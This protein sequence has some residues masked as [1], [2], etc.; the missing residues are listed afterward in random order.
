M[1]LTPL[2]QNLVDRVKDASRRFTPP[3]PLKSGH[4]R[5]PH[6]VTELAMVGQRPP[7]LARQR[8]AVAAETR[9]RLLR[10]TASDTTAG[11]PA[12]LQFPAGSTVPD[13]WSK[14]ML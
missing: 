12:A 3:C 6:E 7:T 10:T 14:L 9:G 4:G 5:V 1:S 11:A 13:H 8:N 2:L